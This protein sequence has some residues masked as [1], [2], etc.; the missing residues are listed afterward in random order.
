M[1]SLI[2]LRGVSTSSG[3][4]A[5]MDRISTDQLANGIQAREMKAEAGMK[6][7]SSQQKGVRTFLREALNLCQWHRRDVSTR[8][9]TAICEIREVERQ[10]EERFS[11][12]LKDSDVL[13]IGCGPFLVQ[14]AYFGQ[15]NTVVG[16]DLD[17]VPQGWKPT[18]YLRMLKVNGA[19]R[20]VK[21][22]VE[23]YWESIG[24]IVVS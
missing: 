23:S 9:S 21:Q 6:S 13:D 5:H 15:C 2:S 11:V 10:V 4:A 1:N 14:M 12:E 16:I 3:Q 8:M 7:Y 17:I 22:S 19:R 18:D 20:T 24:R